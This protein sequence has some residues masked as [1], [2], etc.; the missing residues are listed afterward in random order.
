MSGKSTDLLWVNSQLS[1]S[2]FKNKYFMSVE[3]SMAEC[4]WPVKAGHI[5]FFRSFLLIFSKK[6]L[7]F[8][9]VRILVLISTKCLS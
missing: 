7:Y 8:Y 2:F 5:S 1:A 3:G 4:R 6:I 9:H